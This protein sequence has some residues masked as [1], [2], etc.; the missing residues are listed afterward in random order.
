MNPLN[1]YIKNIPVKTLL[2]SGELDAK[3]TDINIE[4][5]NLFTNAEHTVIKNA[6]HN[7][8]LEERKRFIDTI[9]NFLLVI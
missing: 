3:Y 8:H 5:V 2:I 4:M 6:G 1:K 9:N 7:T